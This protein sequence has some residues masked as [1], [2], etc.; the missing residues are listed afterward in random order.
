MSLSDN[1]D[2]FVDSI[3]DGVEILAKNTVTDAVDQAQSDAQ[4]FIDN[5][6]V[7][8]R[9]W[10]DA[11][12]QGIITRDDFEYLI[13]GQ[14]DLAKLNALKTLGLTQIRLERFRVGLISLIVNSTFT[15][16]GV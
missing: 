4:S 5:S 10:G 14:K 16:I 2:T 3:R 7:S 11:L 13:G 12:A 15:A 6:E 9:R 1:W 8:L